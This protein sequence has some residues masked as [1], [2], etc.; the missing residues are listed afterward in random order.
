M[1]AFQYVTA[2]SAESARELLGPRASFLAGG[3]DL[4][5][6]MKEYLAEPDLLVN[7]K[8]LPGLA[9][10]E[11][12]DHHW[13]L[14]ANV[15][16]AQIENDGQLQKQFPALHEAAAEVGSP[17]IRNVATLG[18]NLAQHS[19]CW[20]Y[21]HRDVSCLKK[22]GPTCFARQGENKFHSLFTGNPCI[23]PV[24]SNLSIALAALGAAVLVQ[25]GKQT[26]RWSL[27]DLYAKAWDNPTAH[28]SLAR[29]DLILKV[30]VPIES[31]RS[32]YEQISEKGAFDW[33]LV[34]CAA[35]VSLEGGRVRQA[36]IVLGAAAPVPYQVEAANDLLKGKE[37]NAA[38]AAQAADQLLAD[39]KPLEHNGY[40]IPMAR[41]L[42]QRTLLKLKG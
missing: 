23:S 12:G 35:A 6:R 4:L 9:R 18:G 5:A 31:N 41:A 36:R 15:T 3:N 32:A 27:A 39:A 24:V 16:V 1:K 29:G 11:P 17:Q 30:E 22:N 7:I 19:R 33:A 20:Y 34:S 40:K 2:Q 28:H 10:I 8:S 14:G 26:L 38:L 42:I 25:Q 21:R 37:I 13:T